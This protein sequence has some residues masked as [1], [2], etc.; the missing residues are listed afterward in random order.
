MK[1][2]DSLRTLIKRRHVGRSSN[3]RIGHGNLCRS[4]EDCGRE[5][6]SVEERLVENDIHRCL[7]ARVDRRTT[8]Q[9]GS[10]MVVIG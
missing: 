4:V 7:Y 3:P 10:S 9:I 6:A 2:D 5:V 8:E 1:N